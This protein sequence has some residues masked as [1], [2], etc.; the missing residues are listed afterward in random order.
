MR[1]Q[2]NYIY[3]KTELGEEIKTE[4]LQQ[5]LEHKRQ[6]KR[7]DDTNGETNP[8]KELIVNNAEKIELLMAQMEQ[9]S[10]L[11]N[12]LNYK[13]YDKYLKNY[14]NLGISMVNKCRNSLDIKKERDVINLDFGPTP[15]ILKEE[16]LHVYKGIQSEILNT[17]RFDKN[18]DL[19]T[20][21]LGKSDSSK[22][23]KLKAEE[24]FPISE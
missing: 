3:K 6:L 8:Y 24:S 22:I 7:V 13:Q 19:S 21:Y 18:S 12:M 11:S 20:T 15:H 14:H 16:Y 1:E 17:L 10:I 5:E 2:A 9:W 4:T 23:D